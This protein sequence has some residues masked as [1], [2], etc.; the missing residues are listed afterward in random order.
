MEN[1]LQKNKPP[2][3]PVLL[4]EI[5]S[6]YPDHFLPQN[7]LDCTFGRGGH[8]LAFLKK[9]P[10]CQVWALDRDQEAI[11]YGK[12]LKEHSQGH[13]HLLQMNFKNFPSQTDQHPSF[14]IVLMD[15]GVSSPQLEQEERG[16]SFYQEGPLDMRMDLNQE[17]TA[18]DVVNSFSKKDLEEIFVKYGEIKRPFAVVND[19]FRQRQKKKFETTKELVDVIGR[20]TSK[21]FS[22]RH[23]ATLYFLALRLFV[24]QELENLESSLPTLFSFLKEGGYF[25]VISFHS[26]E[27]R[28]V[29][30]AFKEWTLDNKGRLWSKKIVR[31]SFQ[32]RKSNPRS[33]SA[34]MRV[35]IKSSQE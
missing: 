13:L 4:S 11:Q 14:D 17:M 21:G 23:P 16:F 30:L 20:H 2:H 12:S 5:V 10:Q 6:L 22:G 34:K 9:Y 27:D 28:I 32:E 3:T 18:A 29:K 35:F 24:N 26:L 7:I 15:L 8:S 25:V 33:R 31:P 19:I 1:F